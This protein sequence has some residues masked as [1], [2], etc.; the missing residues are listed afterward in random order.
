MFG[1]LTTFEKIRGRVFVTVFYSVRETVM[2][3]FATVYI[4]FNRLNIFAG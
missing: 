1:C 3:F 2:M 4:A